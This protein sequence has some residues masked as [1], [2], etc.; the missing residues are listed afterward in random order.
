MP[1]ITSLTCSI[2]DPCSSPTIT[3]TVSV[4]NRD[5]FHQDLEPL[6]LHL[7][8]GQLKGKKIA[9]MKFFCQSKKKQKIWH[10]TVD[11]QISFSFSFPRILSTQT[12]SVLRKVH[13]SLFFLLKIPTFYRKTEKNA[14][15]FHHPQS[16]WHS[17]CL[18]FLS[19]F[20]HKK[21]PIN[22]TEL[23]FS[24]YISDRYRFD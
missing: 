23:R 10:F 8:P 5:A 3:F 12:T 1:T 11:V 17:A 19:K 16:R 15:S 13:L 20:P 9:Q 21:L 4:A 14:N 2:S 24:S 22:E 6:I 7:P 18:W